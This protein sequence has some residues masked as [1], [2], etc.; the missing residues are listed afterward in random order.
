MVGIH[1]E[2]TERRSSPNEDPGLHP[3]E[4]VGASRVALILVVVHMLA[5]R[6]SRGR[7]R[8][9]SGGGSGWEMALLLPRGR[10]LGATSVRGYGPRMI[11]DRSS[12]Q[13]VAPEGK[14]CHKTF[15]VCMPGVRRPENAFQ[16][17]VCAPVP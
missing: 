8:W 13:L 4:S 12:T 16:P 15:A 1:V 10:P 6:H 9:R 2:Q 11:N 5:S 7:G 14:V 17:K 3:V